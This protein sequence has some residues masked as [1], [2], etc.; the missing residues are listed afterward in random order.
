MCEDTKIEEFEESADNFVVV[1]V[2]NRKYEF[3][4]EDIPELKEFFEEI[5]VEH[6]DCSRQTESDQ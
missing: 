4:T 3:A 1:G 6:T 2:G 5:E